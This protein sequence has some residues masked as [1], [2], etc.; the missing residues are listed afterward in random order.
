MLKDAPA[1]LK[2][3]LF[4]GVDLTWSEDSDAKGTCPFC[5]KENHFFVS[6]KKEK[7]GL[8]TC[9]ICG[10]GSE[11]RG[12][13]VYTFIQKFW[14]YSRDVGEYFDDLKELAKSRNLRPS[15]LTKWGIV[16]SH[17]TGE[18]I[19]PGYGLNGSISNLYRYAEFLTPKGQVMR[20][21]QTPTLEASLFGLQLADKEI[22][23]WTILEGPWD[24][25]AYYESLAWTGESD[26]KYVQT[27]DKDSTLIRQMNVV[28]SPGCNT[29]KES[30]A[31]M[32]SGCS[33]DLIY[34]SDHPQVN[35]QTKSIDSPVGYAG[36]E[37]ATRILSPYTQDIRI[38]DWGP[39]GY[40]KS[41]KSG[42]DLSDFRKDVGTIRML[43]QLKLAPVPE[44]W[45]KDAKK[46][47]RNSGSEIEPI[48]TTSYQEV[49]HAWSQ[50]L[51]MT[52]AIDVTIAAM[53]AT[54][55]GCDMKSHSDAVWL[56]V[57][58]PPGS[59]KST[60]IEALAISAHTFSTSVQRGFHSGYTGRGPDDAEGE[61]SS[62]ASLIPLIKNRTVLIKDGDTLLTTPNRD[63]VLS[64]MRD[65]Y[66]GTSRAHFKNKKHSVYKGI[67]T[68]FIIAGTKSLRRL[69]RSYLGDRFIDC[70]IYSR[71][72]KNVELEQK[73][74]SRAALGAL[75]CMRE[76]PTQTE[77]GLVGGALLEAWKRTAGYL[78]W[79]RTPM[80]DG[81]S[82]AYH[83]LCQID[84]PVSAVAECQRFGEYVSFMRARP[85]KEIEEDDNEVELATRLSRQ[86]VRFANLLSVVM[87][88]SVVD[89]QILERTAKLARDTSKGL[90]HSMINLLHKVGTGLDA[91]FIALQTRKSDQ[92]AMAHLKFLHSISA[93]RTRKAS[94]G[95]GARGRERHL[96][97]LTPELKRLCTTLN[98]YRII[99]S[100]P[101]RDAL[102]SSPPEK[103]VTKKK[104]IKKVV[105]KPV[106][107]KTVKRG[108]K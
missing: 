64:E 50:A 77:E 22:K 101:T 91:R 78:N 37:Y 99:T 83:L 75:S 59:A 58:G 88:K 66:D 53:L 35:Q 5:G 45:I 2:P 103:P 24:G 90:N 97:E 49:L 28:A 71:G 7:A 39:D 25:M 26:G 67:N 15:T 51:E 84:C 42:Y 76:Q 11:R 13:N 60:L 72:E 81:H 19:M 73:I 55:I 92:A 70:I 27:K 21:I 74:I 52:E 38:V 62:D 68:T 32:M 85:D 40:D 14:E 18:W 9:K 93:V 1:A 36:M 46:G 41:Q 82:R 57:I 44:E 16:R 4:H 12:G 105:K 30:W 3:Y 10:E 98:Q 94:N 54:A 69:N 107:K 102:R 29:F 95:S 100:M 80:S 34:D 6:Q 33:V 79:L 17:L 20:W 43:Q 56:R 48:E 8:W 106:K 89:A 96:W 47:A 108:R 61:E 65:I 23:K 63:Q 31:K 86:F 104:P 87:N